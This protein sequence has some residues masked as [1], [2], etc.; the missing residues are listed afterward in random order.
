[1][2]LGGRVL[3]DIVFNF[4][5][6]RK[7]VLGVRVFG[8]VGIAE[9]FHAGLAFGQRKERVDILVGH[10][11]ESSR[12]PYGLARRLRQ[13]KS[14]N[15]FHEVGV[16]HEVGRDL[17]LAL[18]GL[19][20]R[21]FLTQAGSAQSHLEGCRG[22]V[23]QGRESLLSPFLLLGFILQSL[24]DLLDGVVLEA[25]VD[26]V[27]QVSAQKDAL[28]LQTRQTSRE[29]R[30]R[31]VDQ[32]QSL[33]EARIVLEG[34]F[35]QTLRQVAQDTRVD[36]VSGNSGVE[37][38]H[39]LQTFRGEGQ[40]GSNLPVKTG[41]EKRASNIRE[42]T[43]VGLGHGEQCFLCRNAEGSVNAETNTTSHGDTI[44]YRDVGLAVTGDKVVDAE[45]E[46]EEVR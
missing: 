42:V 34:Q 20:D 30:N 38:L 6:G 29:F 32:V 21:P 15:T 11:F 9:Q 19:V 13:K 28:F 40:V 5:L 26:G 44:H 17:V 16:S 33:L 37:G 3:T 4:L 23:G 39:T 35:R 18:E 24:E 7:P 31:R 45:F 22:P 25:A 46:S 36:V 1:M 10:F 2:L 8:E 43:N 12:L 14:L 27:P 41:Q